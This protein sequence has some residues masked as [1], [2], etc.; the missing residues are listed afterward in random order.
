MNDIG[1]HLLHFFCIFLE[2]P[3][4]S[5]RRIYQLCDKLQ[6]LWYHSPIKV[7]KVSTQLLSRFYNDLYTNRIYIIVNKRIQNGLIYIIKPKFKKTRW[8]IK[9]W[10]DCLFI[11]LQNKRNSWFILF[12]SNSIWFGKYKW[13]INHHCTIKNILLLNI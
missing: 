5:I 1:L 3:I 13:N 9:Y 7:E 4:S 2:F 12:T 6:F 8:I 11:D 10:K